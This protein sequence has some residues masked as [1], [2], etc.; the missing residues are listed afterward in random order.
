MSNV[1][2][3]FARNPPLQLATISEISFGNT[4]SSFAR[5]TCPQDSRRIENKSAWK[6]GRVNKPINRQQ[7]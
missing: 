1:D 3:P 7:S 5:Q 4:E 6:P 2:K